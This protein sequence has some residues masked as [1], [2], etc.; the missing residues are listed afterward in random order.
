MNVDFLIK[1]EIKRRNVFC[2][3]VVDIIDFCYFKFRV[4]FMVRNVLYL[5]ECSAWAWKDCILLL[6]DD[7]VHTCSLCLFNWCFQF[8]YLL[9]FSLLNTLFHRKV[10]KLSTNIGDLCIFLKVSLTFASH[11][12]TLCAKYIHLKDP[13]VFWRIDSYHVMLFFILPLPK[14]MC[15]EV[16]S[17]ENKYCCS[18]FTLISISMLCFLHL[19]THTLYVSLLSFFFFLS[20]CVFLKK[21]QT[22]TCCF[23]STLII[24]L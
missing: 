23:L 4:C 21:K 12:L 17:V 16:Y 9:I 22:Y 14:K 18:C 1:K 3:H 5:C 11:S 19:T 15:F 8:S 20:R 13:Y 10:K 6:L 24:F 2:Q 7:V